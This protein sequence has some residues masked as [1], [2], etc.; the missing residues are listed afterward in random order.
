M[1]CGTPIGL[2]RSA[3]YGGTDGRTSIYWGYATGS[4]ADDAGR[5]QPQLPDDQA[6]A[7]LDESQ[8]L[9]QAGPITAA[10]GDAILKQVTRINP[11]GQK[12]ITLQVQNLAVTTAEDAHVP[13]S[14]CGKPLPTGFRTVPHSDTSYRILLAPEAARCRRRCRPDGNHLI[15][16]IPA[17]WTADI[18]VR[19]VTGAF[20]PIPVVQTRC[21]V[22]TKRPFAHA[23]GTTGSGGTPTSIIARTHGILSGLLV[24]GLRIHCDV[25][26]KHAVGVDIPPGAA[27]KRR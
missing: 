7:G 22:S 25:V 17:G 13:T 6:I 2:L 5:C 19:S 15:S 16:V 21:A 23:A 8:R 9:G 26:E 1:A 18:F 12:R 10:P 20:A 14:M 24:E 3:R 27:G 11:G 4:T